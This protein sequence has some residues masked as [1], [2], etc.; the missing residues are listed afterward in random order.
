M[1]TKQQPR[2]ENEMKLG[3]FGEKPQPTKAAKKRVKDALKQIAA[4][5][6]I[7]K[8][9]IGADSINLSGDTAKLAKQADEK[10]VRKEFVAKA[11]ANY[12]FIR[13]EFKEFG[14]LCEEADLATSNR[15]AY[16][17]ARILNNDFYRRCQDVRDFFATKSSQDYLV[18]EEAPSTSVRR[19]FSPPNSA[20]P[21]SMFPARC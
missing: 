19:I 15:I 2:S 17:N 13:K 3:S 6:G 14:K 5:E 12:E 4:E 9:A 8:P 21:F 11:Q 10:T 1:A 16:F 18:G 20:S 7:S